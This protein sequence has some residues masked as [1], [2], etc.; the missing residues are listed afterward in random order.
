MLFILIPIYS[1]FLSK[2]ELGEY[3]LILISITL[4]TP[5]ITIQLSD[6]VYRFLLQEENKRTR[7][8][9][10]STGFISII[11]GYLCFLC[12]AFCIDSI[13]QYRFFI[14]FIVL[15]LTFCLFYF[16]QQ[17]TRGLGVSK[18][19][20]LMGVVNSIVVI[21]LSLLFLLVFELGIQGI[22]FALIIAQLGSILL[23]LSFSDI[24]S[25][26]TIRYFEKK[27]ALD[28]IKYSWPLLPN[29]ISWWLIDLGNR[30]IILF[31][32]NEE[33]NGIY[34]IAARY[35]GVIALFNSIFILT[36]Q[37]FIISDSKTKDETEKRASD[38]FNKFVIFELS[39]IILITSASK[40]IIEFTTDIEYHEA[41]N[42]LPILLLSAGFSAFCAYYGAFYLKRKNTFGVFST[43]LIGGLVNIAISVLFINEIGLYA[44]AIGSLIGFATTLIFRMHTFKIKINYNSFGILIL[45]YIGVLL[46]RYYDNLILS[47]FSIV[48]CSFIFLIANKPIILSLYQKGKIFLSKKQ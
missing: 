45:I 41:S 11:I 8:K 12:L 31:Y 21:S 1:F 48:I 19:F 33:F 4:I 3:D 42:Y 26:F 17:L 29:A 14:E 9:I 47:F 37:D 27:V 34:A 43:T 32:L 25:Y 20:A 10:I 39:L 40:Y 18:W 44:V 15:Q 23:I 13:I 7:Q 35:A 38:I 22:L 28:L 30:Y 36:W 2:E 16:F 5:L 46:L 6:A 24:F